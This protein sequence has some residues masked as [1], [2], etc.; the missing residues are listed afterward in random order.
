[1]STMFMKFSGFKRR[2]TSR[3]KLKSTSRL[4]LGLGKRKLK[5]AKKKR[6]KSMLKNTSR[7]MMRFK[8]SK[9]KKNE[10][11]AKDKANDGNKPTY[12]L[13]RLGGNEKKGFFKGLFRRKG[14]AGSGED[15]KNSGLLLGKVAAATNWLTKRFLSTKTQKHKGWG[16]RQSSSRHHH[17]G[18]YN[19]GYEHGEDVYG[20][21]NNSMHAKGY[22]DYYDD[23]G[24]YGEEGALPYDGQGQF[25][26][27]DYDTGEVQDYQDLGY[28]EEDE[29]YDPNL[30]Y[31]EDGLYN[32]GMEDY[33]NPYADPYGYQ[34]QPMAMYGDEGLDYYTLMGE[35]HMYGGAADGFFDPQNQ[36]FY[37]ENGQGVYF[38]DAQ[39]GYFDGQTGFVENPYM[40]NM[41]MQAGFPPDYQLSYADAGMSHPAY[42]APQAAGFPAGGVQ[43]FGGQ[44]MEQVQGLYGDQYADPINQ[45][46]MDTGVQGGDIAFRVPRP[47][48]R[49]FGK[50]RLDVPLPPAPTLP[51]DPEFENMSEI[52]YEDQF[53]LAPGFPADMMPPPQQMMMS[54]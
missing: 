21:G 54:P 16:G 53:P 45:F 48:V 30:Q 40:T 32:E 41:G 37:D 38:S 19:D 17:H 39:G 23:Y 43:N 47:Q 3:K 28:Y 26:Y 24:G 13:L 36:A 49:L 7:F 1:M 10:K 29:L 4:F 51:P 50:E 18:Y 14:G 27:Y 46:G 20:Y 22:E 33:Y 42:S 25:D 31:Y 15:F 9:K 2:R 12:M 44:G 6:R 35:D 8:A 5:S 34:E 11:E 52:Q